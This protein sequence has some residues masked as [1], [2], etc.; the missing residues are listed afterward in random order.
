MKL[1]KRVLLAGIA[2]LVVLGLLAYFTIKVAF[3]PQK[4]RQIVHD[5]GMALL[6]R[7]VTVG[8]VSIRILP[9]LNVS[10]QDI[11]LA[12]A[13]GFSPTAAVQLHELIL[14]IHWMSLLRL[15][16]D[17]SEI[18]LV[19]PEI[20]FEVDRN[21]HHNFEGL[22]GAPKEPK[23]QVAAP[24]GPLELPASFA[25]RSFVI[26][27]GRIRYRDLKEGRELTL[28]NINQKVNL[29]LDPTLRNAQ[30]KGYL[31]IAQVMVE[32]SAAGLRKGDVRVSLSHD[33]RLDLPG[34]KLR[35]KSLE[36]GFQDIKVTV[37]GEVTHF[38]K[39]PPQL[40]LAISAPDIPLASVLKEVP[41]S[42]SPEI[43]K[44]SMS[45]KASLDLKIAGKV[46][47]SRPPDIRGN[48]R[49]EKAAIGHRDVPVGITELGMQVDFLGDTISMPNLGFRMGENPV[50]MQMALHGWQGGKMIL[51]RFKVD[52]KVELLPLIS[53]AQRMGM[54]DEKLS[55]TGT[56]LAA[57]E[58]SGPLDPQRP[59]AI[60][61]KGEVEFTGFAF[62]S[63]AIAV[64][65]KADGKTTFNNER[66]SE[67]AQVTLGKSDFS[68]QSEVSN[69][70]ALVLPKQA[71]QA[72]AKIKADIKSKF[73]DLDELKPKSSSQVQGEAPPMTRYPALP[74]IDAV[75]NISLQQT[76]LLKLDM[77]DFSADIRADGPKVMSQMKGR[78][79]SGSFSSGM[80]LELKD[81]THADVAL[82]FDVNKVEAN[83]FIS[84]LNDQ[85]PGKAK[86]VKG[87]SKLDS[88]L[89]GK[90]NLN[91]DVRTSGLPQ[92]FAQNLTGNILF[93]LVDG[94]ILETGLTAGLSGA[95]SKV[96]SGLGFKE[97]N[98]GLFKADMEAENG[99]LLIRDAKID[100]SPIGA[101]STTGFI[102]L[103][104]SLELKIDQVLPPAAS[105]AV[106][107]VTSAAATS[108]AKATGIT[109]LGQAGLFPRN[110]QG[111]ALL[112]FLVAGTTAR[113]EFKL[114]AKRMAAEASGGAKSAISNAIDAKK[115]EAKARLNAEKEKLENAARAKA[116]SVKQAL[117]AKAAAEKQKAVDEAKK[118]AEPAKE[119]AKSEAK[120]ALKGLGL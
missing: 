64:A 16:P 18:K 83:D 52:A 108:L 84:R 100:K 82:K 38:T 69:W 7:E 77:T 95:L 58:A 6:G 11:H 41:P 28:D 103:D 65:I 94:R 86:M 118:A 4:I 3:P 73:L 61:A 13:P 60:K 20:L 45:G 34:E 55:L 19:K 10:V 79:Y 116:D 78:L 117:E 97:L 80:Q 1:F 26:Y 54:A 76:R 17:V 85:L 90:L 74:P 81:S 112:Y 98:F 37:S 68:V 57:L 5:Q 62:K 30:T 106:L 51:D 92:D 22:G 27:Q 24:S 119:K 87:L 59:E 36:L 50:A 88:T 32:D 89:F 21:G 66:I 35:I 72:R 67:V 44:L 110:S 9:N 63:P 101:L 15:S 104:N 31:T 12:N 25:L 120:K 47:S 102:G 70:Q 91:M 107:G 40:D 33:I 2:L 23:E 105:K 48:F 39:G 99:K 93:M 8:D 56:V 46:D 29:E 115:A 14:S 42:L 113:P 53:L 71:K 109:E 114:D 49:L 43:P 96:H 75:V 111:Q